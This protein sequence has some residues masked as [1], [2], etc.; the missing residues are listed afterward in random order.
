MK[1]VFG[2]RKSIKF[3]QPLVIMASRL[4]NSV[5]RESILNKVLSGLNLKCYLLANTEFRVL[6]CQ[7]GLLL[8]PRLHRQHRPL[9]HHL[10]PLHN[11]ALLSS[12]P[13]F[14]SF[15]QII[16]LESCALR[17]L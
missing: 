11:M 12:L 4:R 2:T 16:D 8:L 13:G 15:V 9:G 1:S 6:V 7:D 10:L 17:F 5:K 14:F 3:A